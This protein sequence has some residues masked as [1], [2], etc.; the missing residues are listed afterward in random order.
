MYVDER[1]PFATGDNIAA[2]HVWTVEVRQ[3]DA[4]SLWSFPD[5][6][7]RPAP[8]APL[9][10]V[11]ISRDLTTSY[12]NMLWYYA[13]SVTLVS[14]RTIWSKPRTCTSQMAWASP[15]PRLLHML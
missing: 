13:W 5:D 8:C 4:P 15:N 11:V 14:V 2:H 12:P 9:E 6:Q 10:S 7:D 1:C 3:I